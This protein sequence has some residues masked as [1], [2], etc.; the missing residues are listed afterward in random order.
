MTAEA[1]PSGLNTD[2]LGGFP[3]SAALLRDKPFG[4]LERRLLSSARTSIPRQVAWMA[5]A[6]F[7][8]VTRKLA[9]ELRVPNPQLRFS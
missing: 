3:A 9:R 7:P 6:V 1:A 2:L 8:R 5:R 4:P